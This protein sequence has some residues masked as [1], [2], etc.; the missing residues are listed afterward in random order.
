MSCRLFEAALDAYFDDQLN[1][2]S[3]AGI[4][5]H[6][7]ACAYCR[8]RLAERQAVATLVRGIPSP[9]APCRLWVRE[10]AGIHS[11]REGFAALSRQLGNA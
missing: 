6:L 2:D 11:D 1:A 3:A 5:E 9:S 4:R 10:L 8:G 7:N